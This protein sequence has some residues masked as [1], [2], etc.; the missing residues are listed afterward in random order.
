LHRYAEP[1]ERTAVGA[2]IDPATA[3]VWFVYGQVLDPY[4]DGGVPYEY[5]C[6]GRMFFAADP[7]E[8]IAV[9]FYDL[10]QATV[11]AFGG[12]R[13]AV[14]REGWALLLSGGMA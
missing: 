3:E 5:E 2:R 6:V 9:S 7:V 4:G 10:P 14:D 13:D 12:K 11:D 8:E 1:A